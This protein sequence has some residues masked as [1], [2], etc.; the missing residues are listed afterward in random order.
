[1]N[2]FFTSECPI[3]CAKFLDDKRALKM[4]LETAQMLSTALRVHGY[5]GDGIYK[6]THKNH[7]S[8]V[9]ARETREN[10]QWL[11]RHFKALSDEYTFRYGKVHKSSRLLDV[12][13]DHEFMIP[14]GSLTP[15]ANCAANK[16]VGVDFK[17]IKDVT[18]AY[19]LYLAV[20][21]DHDVREPTWY[22][23]RK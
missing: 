21:W 8:S 4:V 20:R 22:G 17:H 12:F 13:K 5:E 18:K 6:M 1:M 14:E 16:S 2:I 19:Q 23:V 11:L 9:W 3:E 15:F 10:F 7:P